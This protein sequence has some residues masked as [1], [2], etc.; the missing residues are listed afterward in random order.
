MRT[1]LKQTVLLLLACG[2]MLLVQTGQAQ[3]QNAQDE[4]VLPRPRTDVPIRFNR[5]TVDD[6][7]SNSVVQAILQDRHGFMWHQGRD[8][9]A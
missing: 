8:P 7:L 5:L 1:S 3:P 9:S 2:F 4:A 6:G